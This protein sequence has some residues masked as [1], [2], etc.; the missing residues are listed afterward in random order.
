[1]QSQTVLHLSNNLALMFWTLA[2]HNLE[3]IETGA[4]YT[5]LL[6]PEGNVMG[7]VMTSMTCLTHP[8]F[9][10]LTRSETAITK[11]LRLNVFSM[12]DV[13]IHLKWR[14]IE[15]MSAHVF[16][17]LQLNILIGLS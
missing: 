1:M 13:F 17:N 12:N 7:I 3:V 10:D 4:A 11:L 16:S 2:R 14:H 9:H 8:P 6:V 15:G 5:L